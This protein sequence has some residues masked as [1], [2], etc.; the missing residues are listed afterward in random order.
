[1]V[2]LDLVCSKLDLNRP[3]PRLF[4]F[5]SKENETKAEQ[6]P[7]ELESIEIKDISL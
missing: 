7:Q 5:V 4:G 2:I 3:N 1:M 6:V